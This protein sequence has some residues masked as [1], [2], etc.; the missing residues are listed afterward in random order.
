MKFDAD[1][2]A[3]IKAWTDQA[4]AWIRADIKAGYVPA[5]VRSFIELHDHVDAND[6][7]DV[8]WGDEA[9]PTPSDPDGMRYIIAVQESI[10]AILSEGKSL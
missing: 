4:M 9:P 6:Y 2:Q 8:P 3:S 10:T 5:T 1:D 7:T